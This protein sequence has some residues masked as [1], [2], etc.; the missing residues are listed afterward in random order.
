M[1]YGLIGAS[2]PHSF[3]KIIHEAIGKYEYE[4]TELAP[5]E[6]ASFMKKR[7]FLGI[8]VTIP[9]KQDVMPFLDSISP[10][11]AR[12]GAVNTIVNIDGE[13][14]GFNTDFNGLAELLDKNGVD[15]SGKNVLIIGTGGTSKTAVYTVKF[16]GAAS[17]TVAGRHPFAGQ[18]SIS[19][20][21][22]KCPD[23]EIMINTTPCG[24]YPNVFEAPVDPALFPKLEAV[25]DV[26][27]NPLRTELSMKAQALGIK[28]VCGLYMLVSQAVTSYEIFTGET[29][30]DGL[31]DRI[32]SNLLSAK[33]N[34]VLTGM[35]GS[36]KSTVGR[37]LAR[38]TGR[39]IFDTDELIKEKAGCE[40]AEIFRSSGEAGFRRI[41]SE[42]IRSLAPLSG[43]IISTGGGCV[44]VPGNISALKMNG[45]LCFLDR[46][47]GL[48]VP[49]ED[50]PLSPDRDALTALYKKRLPLYKSCADLIIDNS[51][52][53][54]DAAAAILK[55]LK[56]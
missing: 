13:L 43:V 33:E 31:T 54:D 4:L 38:Q 19:E 45:R 1:K 42:V 27:Y 21:A 20:V 3:S 29:A 25:I 40:I 14:L 16:L 32:Y 36:G 11:A 17:V 51:S 26:I 22:E 41:E 15:V 52:S 56:L 18:I 12:I 23:A 50:R 24:M 46:P 35:P 10:E 34:I 2:L 9:Y 6:L 8:N 44:T 53:A 28:A 5:G 47:V 37:I 49:T 30:E 48:I 39:K 7:A 55:G